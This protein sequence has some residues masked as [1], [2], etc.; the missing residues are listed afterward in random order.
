M[1]LCIG[2]D[3]FLI[4]LWNGMYRLLPAPS[5][6]ENA[7]YYPNH[8]YD[9]DE[10]PVAPGLSRGNWGRK[11]AKSSRWVRRGKIAAWGP[12][13]DDWEVRVY[14]IIRLYS[15]THLS[16]RRKNE[17]ANASSCCYPSKTVIAI[18]RPRL[19]ASHIFGLLHHP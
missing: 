2:A 16:N 9:S 11:A 13:I 15:Y 1:Q 8:G 14:Y 18:V 19:R 5:T 12:G 6:D 17:R 7:W 3:I 4:M 10:E